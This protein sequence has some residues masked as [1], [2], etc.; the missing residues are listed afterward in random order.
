MLLLDK[1]TEVYKLLLYFYLQEIRQLI[2]FHLSIIK[3]S[4][5]ITNNHHKKFPLKISQKELIRNFCDKQIFVMIICEISRVFDD[6]Q[7]KPN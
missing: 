7:M 5:Y 2:R 6:G 3:N 1:P 4:A